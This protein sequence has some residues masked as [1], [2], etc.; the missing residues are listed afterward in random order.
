VAS[1]ELKV[2]NGDPDKNVRFCERCW[3]GTPTIQPGSETSHGVD[4]VGFQNEEKRFNNL[5]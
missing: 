3:R 4:A 5:L 1:A 2:G